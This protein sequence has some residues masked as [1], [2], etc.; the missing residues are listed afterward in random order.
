LARLVV[1]GGG[2]I[3]A[4]ELASRLLAWEESMRIRGSLGLLG[5]STKKALN[6]ILTGTSIDDAG[7]SGTTNG[8][9]M[10]VAPVGV[11]TPPHDLGLLVDRVVAAS[12]VTHNTG[13]ALA[14]AA[15]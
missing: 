10:R 7:R 15:A 3:D 4:A 13:L 14:G 11:A 6:E 8:A 9:A 2:E 5:P 1:D 12:R